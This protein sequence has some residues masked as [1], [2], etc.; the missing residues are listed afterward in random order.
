MT[1]SD[2]F[3]Y[4][5]RSI[6]PRFPLMSSI[7]VCCCCC[8]KSEQCVAVLLTWRCY[9]CT[10]CTFDISWPY[11]LTFTDSW[12]K[13]TNSIFIYSQ[14]FAFST[15]LEDLSVFKQAFK[16]Y[17]VYCQKLDIFSSDC[18][19]SRDLVQHGIIGT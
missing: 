12:S 7:K 4:E 2:R 17:S 8:N 18:N 13:L 11:D 15:G 16:K 19:M 9:W 10:F 1:V 14:R 3:S 5:L 6:W